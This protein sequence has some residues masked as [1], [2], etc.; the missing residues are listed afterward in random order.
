M[1]GS[2]LGYR[3]HRRRLLVHDVHGQRG[4]APRVLCHDLDQGVQ[5]AVRGIEAF[6]AQARGGGVGA[7]PIG[8]GDVQAR[9]AEEAPRIGQ[10]EEGIGA[11]E[12]RVEQQAQACHGGVPVMISEAL[13]SAPGS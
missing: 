5:V 12:R 7:A 8:E 3:N 1:D 9:V 6:V 4:V 13:L 2:P 11:R 10:R